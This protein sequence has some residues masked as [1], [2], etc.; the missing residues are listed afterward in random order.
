M[1][2]IENI[3]YARVISRIFILSLCVLCG[4]TGHYIACIMLCIYLILEDYG[5]SS[6]FEII[7]AYNPE[8][9]K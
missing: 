6:F 4:I 9:Y 7:D 3:I 5:W 2:K 1:S 8:L